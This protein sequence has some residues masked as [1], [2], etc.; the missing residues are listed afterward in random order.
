MPE[1]RSLRLV[2]DVVKQSCLAASSSSSDGERAERAGADSSGSHA[3]FTAAAA[4]R[5]APD[6][7]HSRRDVD[8]VS[9]DTTLPT[10]IAVAAHTATPG[11]SDVK[12]AESRDRT[13]QHLVVESRS[14][15][16]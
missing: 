3:A 6:E 8:I 14:S 15:S 10:C 16:S 2:V 11:D 13:K 7:S 4:V 5:A 9:V 12:R 1:S